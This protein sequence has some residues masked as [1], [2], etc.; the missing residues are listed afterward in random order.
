MERNGR[1]VNESVTFAINRL[2][3]LLLARCAMPLNLAT[4]EFRSS[5][6]VIQSMSEIYFKNRFII[7]FYDFQIK[8]VRRLV[9]AKTN[10]EKQ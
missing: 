10:G 7:E 5:R 2:M 3:S 8:I 1:W 9:S 4:A 6:F